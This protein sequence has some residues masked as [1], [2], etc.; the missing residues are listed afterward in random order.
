MRVEK[1]KQ[2]AKLCPAKPLI[3]S[4]SQQLLINHKPIHTRY[5]AIMDEKKKKIESQVA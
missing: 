4:R 3:N 1:E 5:Q 2:V